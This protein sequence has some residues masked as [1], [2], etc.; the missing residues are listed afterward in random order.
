M[1]LVVSL[2]H[3]Q[4]NVYPNATQTFGALEEIKLV[5]RVC[6]RHFQNFSNRPI[7]KLK[8]RGAESLV[9]LCARWDEYTVSDSRLRTRVQRCNIPQCIGPSKCIYNYTL[10]TPQLGSHRV[11]TL[12]IRN[13]PSWS[14][15]LDTA[16]TFLLPRAVGRTTSL[17]VSSDRATYPGVNI[18]FRKRKAAFTKQKKES[19]RLKNTKSVVFF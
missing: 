19:T 15:I 2:L 5:P 7:Y 1:I 11:C 3:N 18:K 17:D 9:R 6:W 4:R 8:K 12:I 16:I 10:V 13:Q 14:S